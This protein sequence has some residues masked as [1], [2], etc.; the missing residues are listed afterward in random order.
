MK[1][2]KLIAGLLV[3]CGAGVVAGIAFERNVGVGH[4]VDRVGWRHLVMEYRPRDVTDRQ[5]VS[6]PDATGG[7]TMVAL[8]F[9]Q[10][11][12]ANSGETAAGEHAGVLEL[13]RGRMYVARDPL[14]GADGNGGSVW[15]RLGTRLVKS[16]VY[17]RVT[18]VPFAVGG[19][20]I[21]E[22][23]PGGSL[24]RRLLAIIA[25][26]QAK[27]LAFTH[28]LWHQGEADAL[29]GTPGNEYVDRFTAMVSS[30]RQQ[31]IVAPIYVA[32][33]TRC[34]RLRLSEE[35]REAQ[36][37]VVNPGAG[38]LPGPDTDA[39]GFAE[40]YDGCHF[41]SEGLERA[42]ELWADALTTTKR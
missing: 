26:A 29:A 4:W 40:R 22:W 41:S 11:N 3:A 23:A 38:V 34:G 1:R 39:L 7:R 6:F 13:Y 15:L 32:R 33:A 28:L 19:S 12:A 25:E 18:L 14:L 9:G 30:L 10:S 36:G 21:R 31:G 35:I 20:R 5:P 27:G 2:T 42:A 16:G 17:D 24:H 37:V 8:V